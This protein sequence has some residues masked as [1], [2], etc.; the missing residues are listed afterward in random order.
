MKEHETS[1]ELDRRY[2]NLSNNLAQSFNNSNNPISLAFKD[3]V[4]QGHQMLPQ[5]TFDSV[6][7]IDVVL[8]E[9]N[10][11]VYFDGGSISPDYCHVNISTSDA[12]LQTEPEFLMNQRWIVSSGVR[13]GEFIPCFG[14]NSIFGVSLLPVFHGLPRNNNSFDLP[15]R[16]RLLSDC[17]VDL[18]LWYIQL[19]DERRG[20]AHLDDW[21]IM[22]HKESINGLRKSANI[23]KVIDSLEAKAEKET[24]I[25][26]KIRLFGEICNLQKAMTKTLEINRDGYQRQMARDDYEI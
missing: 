3:R 7:D 6:R 19:I 18:T 5:T 20:L 24:S 12:T 8:G 1:V 14:M 25:A 26:E 17:K 11:A 13:K 10:E 22:F 4:S 9:I 21:I 23:K 16:G 15:N 2:R